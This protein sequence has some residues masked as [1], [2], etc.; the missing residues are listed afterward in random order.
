MGD[1]LVLSLHISVDADCCSTSP[2]NPT[3][4]PI[5]P[6]NNTGAISTM[7]SFDGNTGN[8]KK[9]VICNQ[10]IS[11]GDGSFKAECS[12][13]GED[14][15]EFLNGEYVG[16]WKIGNINSRDC[17]LYQYDENGVVTDSLRFEI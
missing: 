12:Y 11:R 9:G 3:Y 8:T 10:F 17:D 14:F 5:L 7:L 4:Y 1:I 13:K 6:R 15:K 2:D 16:P